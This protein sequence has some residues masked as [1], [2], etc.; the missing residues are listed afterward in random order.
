MFDVFGIF[1]GAI[2]VLAVFTLI[3]GALECFAGFKIM[4]VMM[5]VWGFIIGATIGIVI[6]VVSESAGLAISLGLVFGIVL[7]ILAYKLYLAGIFILT[8]TLTFATIY[9]VSK[10]VPVGVI[11]GLVVGVAAMFFVRIVVICSTAVSGAGMILSS[12]YALM[13]LNADSIMIILWIPIALAGILCQFMTTSK[14]AAIASLKI[15]QDKRDGDTMTFSE[16]RYPGM[17]RAYRNFCI[18]CGCEMSGSEKCPRCGFE[19]GDI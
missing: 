8:S 10:S 4:K 5:S 2:K 14:T 19:I 17:Q 12:A 7:A 15:F 9:L 3:I 6:G 18:K 1:D 16:R 13:E 11:I